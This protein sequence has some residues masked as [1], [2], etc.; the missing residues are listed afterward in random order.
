MS[1]LYV[2]FESSMTPRYFVLVIRVTFLLKIL[3]G[4]YY[5]V[6]HVIVS[7]TD[8]KCTYLY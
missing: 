2:S 7:K 4:E 3:L 8:L 6:S 1:A 5:C